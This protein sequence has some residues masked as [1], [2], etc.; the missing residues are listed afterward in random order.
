MR[1][2]KKSCYKGGNVSET[3]LFSIALR[4]TPQMLLSGLESHTRDEVKAMIVDGKNH[5]VIG[6]KIIRPYYIHT[7]SLFTYVRNAG[8]STFLINGVFLTKLINFRT[9]SYY[10]TFFTNKNGPIL[11]RSNFL[12]RSKTM[13]LLI[14]YAP[15]LTVLSNRTLFLIVRK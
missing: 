8:K 2:Q 12:Q 11:F 7:L 6:C 13:T 5:N 15:L 3:Y 14:F 4:W 9:Q 10:K 1:C